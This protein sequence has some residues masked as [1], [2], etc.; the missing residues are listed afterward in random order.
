M[1]KMVEMKKSYQPNVSSVTSSENEFT[2]QG[3]PNVRQVDYLWFL[4]NPFKEMSLKW[5]LVHQFYWLMNDLK[6][7][8]W[9]Q[10]IDHIE[11]FILRIKEGDSEFEKIVKVNFN[12][13]GSKWAL[14]EFSKVFQK[15]KI[16]QILRETKIIS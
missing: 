16:Q 13:P 8:P 2:K 3:V 11:D 14:T 9:K 10:M 6:D 5:R 15:A 1:N 7:Y 12:F 4:L